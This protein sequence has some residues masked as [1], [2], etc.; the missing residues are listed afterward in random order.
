M[1][2]ITLLLAIFVAVG[3][4]APSPAAAQSNKKTIPLLWQ[5]TNLSATPRDSTSASLEISE[6]D[7]T[8]PAAISDSSAQNGGMSAAFWASEDTV[9]ALIKAQFGIYD[10]VN[11]AYKWSAATVTTCDSLTLG[12][13]T[14]A[15]NNPATEPM[16]FRTPAGMTHVRFIVTTATNIGQWLLTTGLKRTVPAK[17]YGQLTI[18]K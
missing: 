11:K 7:T 18:P 9:Q 13:H 3:A 17:L 8:Q 10:Q 4:L 1:R 16:N 12:Y 15:L 5:R 2:I 14:G 6:S